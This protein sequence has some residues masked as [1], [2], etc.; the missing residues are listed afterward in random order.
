[1]EI[2]NLRN[3]AEI[4]FARAVILQFRTNVDANYLVE[5]VSEMIKNENFHLA[6]IPTDDGTKAAAFV[7]FRF[8]NM[9]RTGETIY[10]DDLF[11]SPEYR[12]RGYAAKLLDYVHQ[13]AKDK[14]LQTVHLDSGFT[15]HP[16]HKLYISK[17]YIL[18]CHHFVKTV[19]L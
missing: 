16:A 13:L 14:G 19:G 17:G 2:L 15:L 5:Q 4:E 10:I 8:M 12:S 9:L 7:G 6:C 18:G 11:T 1:M 3:P